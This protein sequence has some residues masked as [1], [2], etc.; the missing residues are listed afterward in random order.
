MNQTDSGWR[1]L[2][3]TQKQ[4]FSQ[5]G[6]GGDMPP[7]VIC[8]R[9]GKP[10][11]C[12]IAPTV[13]KHLAL[14]A[15][16]LLRGAFACDAITLI[17]DGYTLKNPTKEDA[18]KFYGKGV[19]MQEAFINGSEKISECITCMHY[20]TDGKI[21]LSMMPYVFKDGDVQWGKEETL[22]EK[23]DGEIKGFL[24]ESLREIMSRQTCL[25]MEPLQQ[26]VEYFGIEG[27]EKQLHHTGRAARSIL[28]NKDYLIIE[29]FELDPNESPENF[30]EQFKA[31]Y[32]EIKDL[33]E[34]FKDTWGFK[35]TPFGEGDTGPKRPHADGRMI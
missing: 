23:K 28:K 11:I 5:M 22:S 24:A 32:E 26:A 7:V 14:N 10:Q 27:E 9:K 8:E 13:D 35:N 29:C 25:E 16:L 1:N 4:V 20:G 18:E 3:K 2:A 17:T 19:S 12:V 33:P 34:C 21:E 31:K 30:Q 15:A 6:N